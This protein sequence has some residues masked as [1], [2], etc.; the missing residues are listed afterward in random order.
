MK[1]LLKLL[2]VLL[3]L[4]GCTTQ[5]DDGFISRSEDELRDLL[6]DSNA[7][8]LRGEIFYNIFPISFAD[9]NGDG[10]GDLQGIIKSLDYL[11]EMGV[12]GLWLNPIHPSPSYHKYDVTD[13]YDIDP[14]F[15][16]LEDFKELIQEVHDRD[17]VLIMDMV[18][19]HSSSKH[20]WFIKAMNNEEDYDD[21]Y[22]KAASRDE[23]PAQDKSAWYEY[24][25]QYY[26]GSFWSEMPEF[27]LESD[28]VRKEFRDILSFWLD[29]GVD[30]FR[31]DAAK[32]A[33][34]VN[35]YSAGTSTL[36]KNLQFWLEMK[37]HV[38]SESPE[39][40]VIAEVWTDNKSMAYYTEAFD[41]LFNFDFGQG[42]IS[43]IRDQNS[44]AFLSPYIKGQKFFE[45]YPNYL[46]GIF[47]S[48]HDQPRIGSLLDGQWDLLR[49][50]GSILLT[51]PGNPYIYYGEELAYYG[52][53][54]DERIREPL[55]WDGYAEIQTPT[56]ED[57]QLNSN[58]P[59]V[60]EQL[61]DEN[62]LL[63]HY[64]VWGSY[65]RSSNVLKQGDFTNLMTGNQRIMAYTR[66]L[67]GETLLIVLNLS[68]N[69]QQVDLEMSGTIE[70]NN[71][72]NSLD[73]SLIT[74]QPY[75]SIIIK[76]T[77]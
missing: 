21:Y 72:D 29:L 17:M 3:L 66:S 8:K 56:W 49:L 1:H 61:N 68:N 11:S 19:N 63:T 45:E 57:I 36:R 9:G 23:I 2:L 7:E 64:Q 39:A 34:D 22:I 43:S 10:Y 69:Q 44:T 26:Y 40:Y 14:Q 59:T 13:Y 60:Q 37:H 52:V 77:P 12:K 54:P 50:G 71:K 51:M 25:G 6:Q 15:G 18:L 4:V 5:T 75:G 31:Y 28:S 53:K 30:G 32:H 38:K 67:N 46:D 55:K 70:V 62:S 58:T 74:L 16:T 42:V 76:V 24:N 73:G 47:L 33:Y 35:E 48:N 65:R 20:P 27:N 41:A